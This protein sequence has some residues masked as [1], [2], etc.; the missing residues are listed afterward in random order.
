MSG[1]LLFVA[2]RSGGGGGKRRYR[3]APGRA[4]LS[5]GGAGAAGVQ[6]LLRECCATL[7]TREGGWGHDT[8]VESGGAF[9]DV[10]IFACIVS[11]LHNCL[12]SM[13]L[14]ALNGMRR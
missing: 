8:W 1:R 13:H 5:R 10:H 3:G 2:A 4:L 12:L 9:S 7:F 11:H 6:R 14:I